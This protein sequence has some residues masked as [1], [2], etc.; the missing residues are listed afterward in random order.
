MDRIVSADELKSWINNYKHNKDLPVYTNWGVA[1]IDEVIGFLTRARSKGAF[2]VSIALVRFPLDA[3]GPESSGTGKP[4]IKTVGL[5]LSQVS[6][7][8]I[9]GDSPVKEPWVMT[10]KKVDGHHRVFCICKGDKML[11]EDPS[12]LCPPQGSDII[13]EED[14]D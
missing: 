1:M 9:T 5:G 4:R 8:L 7:A 2:A 14:D 10:A 11:I 6:F 13:I 3:D 12:G